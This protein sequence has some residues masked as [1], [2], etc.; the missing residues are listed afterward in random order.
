[1]GPVWRFLPK[2]VSDEVEVLPAWMI[3]VTGELVEFLRDGQ[4]GDLR[5]GLG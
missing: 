4:V 2:V 1:M 5:L 3:N